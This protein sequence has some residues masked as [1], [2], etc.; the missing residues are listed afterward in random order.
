MPFAADLGAAIKGGCEYRVTVVAHHFKKLSAVLGVGFIYNEP[1]THRSQWQSRNA[2]GITKSIRLASYG[3]A[4]V[5]DVVTHTSVAKATFGFDAVVANFGSEAR[6]FKV[7][8]AIAAW[9]G[10]KALG[11]PMAF[12]SL[13]M[14]TVRVAA[15]ANA[16]VSVRGIPWR[17]GNSSYWWPN[18][19]FRDAYTP[20]L[21]VLT[22]SVSAAN[23]PVAT[24]EHRFG[25]VEW[26]EAPD[27]QTWYTVNGRRINFISDAT[28]EAA[29]SSYDCYTTSPAFSTLEGAKETWRRYMRIG[30]SRSNALL[31]TLSSDADR[32]PPDERQPHP[33]VDADA[34]HV[35]RRGRGGLCAAARD[36]HPRR[37]P[38]ENPLVFRPLILSL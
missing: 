8:A 29:M 36:R 5:T 35:G 27:N 31:T 10:S 24:A 34:D 25:F 2:F 26:A 7:S 16:T 15:G 13:P 12:P 18:K 37:V 22:L 6:Q 14:Q 28:P 9:N 17:L 3:A 23:A 20:Q 32:P 30:V 1:W 38:G 19:P 4:A 11:M 33:P 21:Q